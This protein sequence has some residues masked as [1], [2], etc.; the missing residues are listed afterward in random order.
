MLSTS[1]R[2]LWL[3]ATTLLLFCA[4]CSSP[5]Y[6]YRYVPGRTAILRDGYAIAPPTA[7]PEVKAAIAAGN[8]INGLPY[9]YGGGHGRGVD[10]A[11]D[12]S[13]AVS[14]VLSGAG[15]LRAPTTSKALRKYGEPGEGE[16]ISVY[17]RRNHSF[18]VVA[19]LRFDTGWTG[20]EEGPRWTT[21]SRPAP[22][23]VIRH[24]RGL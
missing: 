2:L 18:V 1:P 17:A 8:R 7:P 16:W 23:S 11:Y 20:Q 19:G 12:C 4:G 15:R 5:H 3:L 24:P 22:G 13:G 14:F 10:T 21:R 9:R 6:E